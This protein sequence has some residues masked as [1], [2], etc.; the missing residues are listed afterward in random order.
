[1]SKMLWT[2]PLYRFRIPENGNE[3]SLNLKEV[4]IDVTGSAP[5]FTK[6]SEALKA[7]LKDIFSDKSLGK[8]EKV[9]EFGAG[10]LKNLPFILDQDKIVCAVEF[11]KLSKN[12]FAKKNLKKCEKYKGKFQSLICPNPFLSD[13]KKFDLALL[14]NVPSV[15]PVLAERMYLL[16]QLY[17]KIIDEKYLLWVAQKEGSYKEIREDGK[18]ACGDGIWMGKNRKLKTFYKYNKIRDLDEMMALYGFEFVKR[19]NYGDD[20][21]LYKKTNHILFRGMITQKRIL[22]CIPQDKTIKDPTD[23]KPK[24]VKRS[25]KLAPIVPDPKELSI[26][27]LYIER[28]RGIKSGSENAEIYHRVVSYALDRVFRDSFKNMKIKQPVN[29]RSMI[30]DTIFSNC[31]EK[32]FFKRLQNKG[33]DC[34]YPLIEIKNIS[35]DPVND[36]IN[37]VNG[38]MSLNRGKFG[39]L[40]CRDIKNEEAVYKKCKT[41]LPERHILFLTDKDIINF[42]ELSREGAN[43]EIDDIMDDKLNTLLFKTGE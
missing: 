42:L 27:S 26:E 30:L 4:V 36:E 10:K 32:G 1:M 23:V 6:P 11:E 8:I 43:D 16:Q 39:I 13:K 29:D 17:D 33:V 25:F 31:A 21:R 24:I 14:L 20:I 9:L 40:V 5:P 18:N 41:H 19:Y 7:V 15:M 3:E 35:T 12:A 22:D 2:N 38:S 34:A 28:I 37:Q